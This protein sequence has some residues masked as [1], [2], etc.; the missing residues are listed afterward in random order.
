[1]NL[2]T[3]IA[4]G[5]T[6][7]IV[8]SIFALPGTAAS[9]APPAP[10]STVS[11]ARAAV[12]L[13]VIGTLPDGSAF[14]GALSQLTTSVVNGI[15]MLSGLITGTG[16]PVAGTPFTTAV[17]AQ[18]TCRV[19]TLSLSALT[20]PVLGSVNL[21]PIN[22]V[23]DAVNGLGALLGN[24]VGNLLCA[25]GGILGPTVVSLPLVGPLFAQV[26]PALGLGPVPG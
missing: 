15:P 18:S 3:R 22:L 2:R 17:S 25:L 19:L 10:A 5:F 7:A 4:A 1:M 20:L 21:A 6:A 8:A 9:A 23:A 16:L 11:A 26:I 13:P 12:D 14:T 24:L